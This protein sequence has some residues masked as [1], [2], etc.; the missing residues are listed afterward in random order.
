MGLKGNKTH[1]NN[2]KTNK[3]KNLMNHLVSQG[4]QRLLSLGPQ[5]KKKKTV[6]ERLG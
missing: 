6:S 4:F 5:K 1:G 2:S 3:K